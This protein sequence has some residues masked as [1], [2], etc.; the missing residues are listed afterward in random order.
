MPVLQLHLVLCTTFTS[1]ANK[2]QFLELCP[3]F[4]ERLAAVGQLSQPVRALQPSTIKTNYRSEF[5]QCLEPWIGQMAVSQHMAELA[6]TSRL[7]ETAPPPTKKQQNIMKSKLLES[8]SSFSSHCRSFESQIRELNQQFNTVRERVNELHKDISALRKAQSP[9]LTSRYEMLTRDCIKLDQSLE[10]QQQELDRMAAV[11]DA[12]WEEQLWRLRVEQ[13]VFSCQ[14]AD[15]MTLRN[16][17]KQLSTLAAQLEPYIRSLTPVTSSQG[18][19]GHEQGV[20]E[21]AQQ[22]QNLLEHIGERLR[23]YGNKK[24]KKWH[25]L[26][27]SLVRFFGRNGQKK[28]N[29]YWI[30]G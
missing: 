21:H 8:E 26:C 25:L 6:E 19:S 9:P 1:A 4:I 10:R 5:A 2:Y 28:K 7:Y 29:L 13:E 11:F 27:C 18:A 17:L 12:S 14:R 22:L 30:L 20:T 24:V 3:S 16:E 15:V 23:L